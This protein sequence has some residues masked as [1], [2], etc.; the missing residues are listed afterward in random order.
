MDLTES[1][2]RSDMEDAEGRKERERVNYVI[3]F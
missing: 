3:K 2:W 1:K